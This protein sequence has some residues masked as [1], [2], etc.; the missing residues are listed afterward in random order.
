[1]KTMARQLHYIVACT[2][3]L[4]LTSIA[5]L[6]I[7]SP[8]GTVPYMVTPFV[9]P[10]VG[11][12]AYNCPNCGA[13]AHQYWST[14]T[15]PQFRT[16]QFLPGIRIG[17]CASCGGYSLWNLQAMVFPVGSSSAPTPHPDLPN[18]IKLDFNEARAIAAQSP[19]GAAALLRLSVQKLCVHLGEKGKNI[20]DDIA[21][22]VAKGLPAKIQK[23]MD[24]VRIVGNEA[25]H[26]GEM[27][28]KDDQETVKILFDLVNL[29]VEH[30]IARPK[31]VD[32]L[33]ERL[34][35]EKR[36]QIAQRDAAAAS[37]PTGKPA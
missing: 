31:S 3:S 13:F 29:V 19:R 23:A 32:E 12:T 17:R 37:P 7:Q 16:G 5:H 2:I 28:I 35:E 6:T 27:D 33:F 34:P 18:A 15:A 24:V 14:V 21:S 1:M 22:L 11:A 30:M 8:R 4:Y 26:P 20:N 9:T 25:V 10:T 36:K